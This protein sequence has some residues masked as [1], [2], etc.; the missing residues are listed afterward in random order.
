MCLRWNLTQGIYRPYF[1]WGEIK[2]IVDRNKLYQVYIYNENKT[3]EL[4]MRTGKK[5]ICEGTFSETFY[6]FYAR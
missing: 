1:C 4:G 3:D 5:Y 6:Y 2:S